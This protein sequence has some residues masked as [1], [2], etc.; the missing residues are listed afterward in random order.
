MTDDIFELELRTMAHGGRA[1][2][3][4]QG[5][6]VF[7]P[8][9]IPG[10]R[11]EARLSG[12]SGRVAFAEG[13]RL[14]EASADRVWPQCPHF[15]PG[16]CGQCQWQHI[17][18]AAQL[19]LKQD[20]LADQLARIGG[21]DDV[22][23]LPTIPAPATRGYRWGLTLRVNRAGQPGL[24]SERA[25]QVVWPEACHV[26]HPDLLELL[27]T[28]ELDIDGLRELRLLRGS[29]GALMLLL[30]MRNDRAPELLS[31]LPAS[32]NML[33]KG[34]EPVNL[35][36][37]S[38][39]VREVA[40]RRFRVTAGSS[41]RAHD[42]L[43]PRLATLVRQWLAPKAGEHVLD[44]YA[45]V[46]F[47]SA[48]LAEDAGLVTLVERFPPAVT[49]AESNLEAFDNIDLIEGR[50]EEV[51]PELDTPVDAALVDPPREGLSAEAVDSLAAC[52]AARLV[53]VSGDAA[54]LA[55]D[56]RRLRARG[57]QLRQAQPVDLEPLT[58][59]IDTVALLERRA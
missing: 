4:H 25:G 32:V 21:L 52:G 19:L 27:P 50:V 14:L 23:V 55:R 48:F 38:H 40:G 28:L 3:R 43:L 22:E 5:Q 15:G 35:I 31:D 37:A 44:L 12:R 58:W 17:D 34:G 30:T 13:L 16:R 8:Y 33:L 39:L 24:P 51:L 7:V 59:R 36:G 20:V 26:A 11:I 6:V 46:G 47:F 54:T 56:A 57:W 42:A 1:M 10:E 41:F 2:G 29:D 9:A 18:Y 53:Y 45:G 49:D